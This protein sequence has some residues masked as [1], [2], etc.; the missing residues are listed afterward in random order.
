MTI[1]QRKA[2]IKILEAK[3]NAGNVK[4]MFALRMRINRLKNELILEENK[5]KF[6]NFLAQ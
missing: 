1:H 2:Q 6:Q 3:L 5:T 4:S